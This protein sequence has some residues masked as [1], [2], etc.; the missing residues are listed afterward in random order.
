MGRAL[1]ILGRVV[2]TGCLPCLLV[3]ALCASPPAHASDP[4]NRVSAGV[5]TTC[6]L[7]GAGGVECWGWNFYGSLGM[8]ALNGPQNCYTASNP[9]GCSIAPV[10]VRGLGSGV[11]ALASGYAHTCALT[12][13]GAVECWG[14]N[15]AGQ[16]GDG[17]NS[18]P[19]LCSSEHPTPCSSVPVTVSGLGSGVIAI[20]SGW[21]QTCAVMSSGDLKCWGNNGDGQLGDGTTTDSSTPVTV[22]LPPGVK[23]TAVAGGNQ[24]MCALTDTGGVECWGYNGWGLLGIGTETGPQ[25]CAENPCS[26]TPV[27][28][29]L[30]EGVTA[31]A[32]ASGGYH[33]CV[34]TNLGGVM[35]W[36]RGDEGELGDG[37]DTES[38]TPVPV[39]LPE[40]VTVTAIASESFH[41][42]ALT[43]TGGVEC[44]GYNGNAQLGDG[45]FTGPETCGSELP[46]GTVPVAVS[47]LEGSTVAIAT[48]GEYGCAV[49][50]TGGMQCWGYDG[51][52]GLGVGNT[53]F[54]L[55]PAPVL[56]LMSSLSVSVAGAGSGSVYSSAPGI[57]C[58][59]PAP[60]SCTA[61]FAPS[62]TVTLRAATASG[63]AFVGFTGSGC[64]GATCTLP[65]SEA[66][67]V[68][69]TFARA[70][71]ASIAA[72]AEGG[73]YTVGE[74]APTSFSC[75]EGSS[76][77]GLS[78]CNDS[79]GAST[80]GG[81]AG[82]LDTSTAGAHTYTVTAISKDGAKSSASI[83]YTVK[84]APGI[85]TPTTP[86]PAAPGP[87]AP[88]PRPPV[89]VLKISLEGLLG[90]V[91]HGHTG[92]ELRCSGGLVGACR[93]TLVLT[94]R[95]RLAKRVHG[96]RRPAYETIVLARADYDVHS[97]HRE[98]VVLWLTN[99]GLRLLYG[100]RGNRVRA[101]ATVTLGDRRA[102]YRTL[103]LQ[104]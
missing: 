84:A 79:S 75:A 61:L 83:G 103:T 59:V 27:A 37:A 45:T 12:D 90:P 9:V 70:P 10:A 43:S 23:A 96:R 30:P 26:T 58:G 57:D 87:S 93:G 8:G 14:Y 54:S 29:H 32:I 89:P 34:V 24:H 31:T 92:V 41:T 17:T 88:T 81:G 60:T 1:T 25:S 100:A 104:G 52:G 63:S 11:S 49:A 22:Q 82:A 5:G 4:V 7:T 74:A 102:A 67:S 50:E 62:S 38:W 47:G 98:R 101:Q 6:A 94:A 91:V 95:R 18:G 85:P 2:R 28:V 39:T 68:S 55:N 64:G 65:M 53:A 35:C 77:P 33:T 16:I 13:A 97:A 66:H 36:G 19:Q 46:C 20:G 40:G 73:T 72:P 71:L 3:L 21:D 78:S 69:A 15:G 44:W 76:G 80:A 48:G 56:E 51:T 86:P 99:P 42:C